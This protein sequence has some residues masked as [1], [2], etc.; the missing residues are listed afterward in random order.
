MDHMG[1]HDLNLSVSSQKRGLLICDEFSGMVFIHICSNLAS[2]GITEGVRF[3]AGTELDKVL[4]LCSDG[5]KA[6]RRAA[7]ALGV[8]QRCSTPNR[9]HEQQMR[10]QD[11]NREGWRSQLASSIR[12]RLKI[13]SARRVVVRHDVQLPERRIC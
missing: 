11:A 10:T 7:R 8:A 5:A 9:K 4:V 13:L 2:T 1:D 6:F 12:S 3:F